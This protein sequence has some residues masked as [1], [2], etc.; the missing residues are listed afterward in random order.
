MKTYAMGWCLSALV[1]S[2]AIVLGGCGG[3][4]VVDFGTGGATGTSGSPTSGST[5]TSG[6][7]GTGGAG[8]SNTSATG[9]TTSGSS[10]SSGS[11][12]SSSSTGG[13]S[14]AATPND[15]TCVACAK[16]TCCSDYTKC[17]ADPNCTC[18]VGCL[19]LDPTNFQ[20]CFGQC[21]APDATT[22]T[23]GQCVNGGCQA[24]CSGGIGSSSSSGSGPGSSS[25]SSSSSSGS[26]SSSSASTGT[27]G[28]LCNPAPNDTVCTTCAKQN[29]C[30]ETNACLADVKCTCWVVCTQQNPNNPAACFQQCGAPDQQTTA[31]GQCTQQQC[32]GKCP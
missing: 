17:E 13:G 19:A 14:C 29:C 23:F 3:S 6:T 25:A 18:W 11:S 20:G 16:T 7:N 30:A 32:Q 8:G 1:G 4:S 12:M 5:M 28:N 26:G 21:G 9:S 22:Q 15:S 27:G 2:T 31:I 24:E 10:V